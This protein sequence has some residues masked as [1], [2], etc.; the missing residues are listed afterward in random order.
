MPKC[1]VCRERLE[2][3]VEGLRWCEKAELEK[4]DE[5]L[6]KVQREF[7]QHITLQD[8]N[9]GECLDVEELARVR[10]IL[11]MLAN[12]NV[13]QM[14]LKQSIG[15]LHKKQPVF[16]FILSIDKIKRMC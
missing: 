5:V 11:S 12:A 1:K 6:E 14:S 8:P 3:V 2:N 4:A 7:G 16:L 10:G 9:T 15:R 13:L